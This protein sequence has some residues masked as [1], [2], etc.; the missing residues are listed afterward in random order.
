MGHKRKNGE[1]TYGDKEINGKLYKYYRTA[2]GKYIYGKTQSELTAKIKEY[3][4]QQKDDEILTNKSSK[5]LTIGEYAHQWL[6]GKKL[7][8]KPKT[9]DGY[10]FTV[11]VIC[12]KKFMFGDMQLRSIQKEQV[13]N[14]I[15]ELAEH[16]AR[17]TIIKTRVILNQIFEDAVDK[18]IILRNPVRKTKVP[19]E[20][21]IKKQTKEIVILEES[22]IIK[23]IAE[24]KCIN[25]DG[26]HKPCGRIGE[27]R[28]GICSE[29]ALFILNTGL[30][31]SEA[32]GLKWKYVDLEKKTIYIKN[33]TTY[34]KDRDV[35]STK[36]NKLHDGTPKSKTS[37]R[38]IPLSDMAVE[39][40][41]KR[42]EN[43]N[44]EYVF[45][46]DNGTQLLNSNLDKTINRIL[47]NGEC[48]ITEI[49][50]HALRHTF[51]SQLIAQGVDIQVI[52][53]LLGHSKVSTTYNIY[54]HLLQKQ[55]E[56]AIKVLNKGIL[57][58][59]I[60]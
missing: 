51:A 38:T 27:P 42:K 43:R 24:A 37:I 54:I 10:E 5:A 32:I 46:T 55:D 28:Y 30:R 16:Y 60:A 18:E 23:F 39:I 6:I 35:N 20:E 29:M 13:Q 44:S 1:G 59:P 15:S 34:I 14:F 45:T 36:K 31:A 8:I 25:G 33:A 41:K 9:Y 2:S 3:N 53:K 21:N 22:D 48:D 50:A 56:K 57:G 7:Y 19:L 26:R 4:K 52:S 40:L 47:I 11:N 49:G 58:L 12:D 17:N